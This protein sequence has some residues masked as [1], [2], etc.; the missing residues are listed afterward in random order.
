MDVE[1]VLAGV[2]YFIRLSLLIAV[3]VSIW[4]GKW[5][6]FF[7]SVVVFLL[8]FLP[9]W[10]E[11]N[12][13]ISL[14]L[15]FE[16]VIIFFIYATLY[17]GE[18]QEFYFRFWWWDI[19]LH[20][21]SALVFGFIGFLIVYTLTSEQGVKVDLS[22]EF[23]FLFSFAFAIMIGAVWEIY[24]FAMD[25]GFGLNMQKSGLVDTMW[26]LIIDAVGALIASLSGYLYVKGGET[27][28]FEDL[29]QK[30]AEKNPEMFGKG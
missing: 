4:E 27:H 17:L 28:W 25:V 10:I 22:P 11:D 1:K 14:P 3:G 20:G 6:T 21:I 30:F 18:V 9:A 26:D 16:F 24:E 23:I 12:Y 19:F 2:S 8:T 5:M 13:L 29:V 7:I 15:E